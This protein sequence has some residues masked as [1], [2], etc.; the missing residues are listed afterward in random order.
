MRINTL[1][2]V[3][4]SAIVLTGCGP[5]STGSNPPPNPAVS[6][7][8]NVDSFTVRDQDGLA[9]VMPNTVFFDFYRGLEPVNAGDDQNTASTIRGRLDELMGLT[10]SEDGKT[11]I[12]ARNP[13]DFLNHMIA[14]NRVVSFND[15]R[16]L[17]RQAATESIAARYNNQPNDATIRFTEVIENEGGGPPQET[18]WV[19]PLLDWTSNP[20]T[21]DDPQDDTVSSARQ[22][23]A[24]PPAD[25]SETPAEVQSIFWS[26]RFAAPEFSVSGHNRPEFA[27]FTQTARTLGNLELRKEYID[28]RTDTMFLI[29]PAPEGASEMACNGDNLPPAQ[30]LDI[31]IAGEN[32]DCVRV[33]VDYADSQVRVFTSRGEAVLTEDCEAFN[34]NYCGAQSIANDQQAVIYDG[35]TINSRQ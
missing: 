19:F 14:D 26:A 8:E 24:R 18:L 34:I 5:E 4:A 22:F 21:N 25:D 20:Q 1:P 30:P 27:I 15:G 9:P 7:S 31:T 23:V 2:A 16:Q 6:V 11:Y 29:G 13:L 12:A 28:N 33:E 17:M 35:I 3:I 10:P 32:P